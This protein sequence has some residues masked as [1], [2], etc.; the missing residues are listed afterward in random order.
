MGLGPPLHD[1]LLSKCIRQ[2]LVPK[3]HFVAN[4]HMYHSDPN[5]LRRSYKL[6]STFVI[7]AC[8]YE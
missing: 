2:H 6:N 3:N 5:S 4:K 7:C 8:R 1:P